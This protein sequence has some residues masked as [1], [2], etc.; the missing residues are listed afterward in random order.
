MKTYAERV[1][2]ATN[3]GRH[4][5]PQEIRREGQALVDEVKRLLK[6][7][8]PFVEFSRREFR[9]LESVRKSLIYLEDILD[10]QERIV[11]RI[12]RNAKEFKQLAHMI[13]Q[14]RSVNS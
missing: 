1:K 3:N 4:L 13:H 9:V 5:A 12:R 11:K 7:L 8:G 10:R 2:I 14:H 6:E